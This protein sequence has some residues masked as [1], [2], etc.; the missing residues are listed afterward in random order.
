MYCHVPQTIGKFSESLLFLFVTLL[1]P[2][3]A[4]TVFIH[5]VIF[6][7]SIFSFMCNIPFSLFR[8]ASFHLWLGTSLCFC[9]VCVQLYSYYQCL[10]SFFIVPRSFLSFFRWVA[11]F[12]FAVQFYFYY[13]FFTFFLIAPRFF[14]SICSG[15]PQGLI[16]FRFISV[17]HSPIGSIFYQH[18]FYPHSVYGAEQTCFLLGH[19]MLIAWQLLSLASFLHSPN[20]SHQWSFLKSVAN[21][22][23]VWNCLA[24]RSLI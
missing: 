5:V 6:F 16:C 2:L 20:F 19:S 24:E 17:F 18:L 22:L 15:V 11:H 4:F 13:Q 1:Y 23:I 12:V 9:V 8:C 21:E 7:A 14:L 3:F 10:S